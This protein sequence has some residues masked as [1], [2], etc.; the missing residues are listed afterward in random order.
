MTLSDAG[1]VVVPIDDRLIAHVE[2]VCDAVVIKLLNASPEMLRAA[3]LSRV[4]TLVIGPS[5]PMLGGASSAYSWAWDFMTDARSKA[6]LLLR[7]F[8]LLQVA[9]GSHSADGPSARKEPLVLLADDDPDLTIL[10]EATLRNDGIASRIANNGLDT[11]RL[12]RELLP[13]LVV[14]DVRMPGM[15]GFAVL[16]TIRIDPSLQTMPVILLTGCDDP[17]D[18]ALGAKLKASDYLRKPVSPGGLLVRVRRSLTA[19]AT[20]STRWVRVSPGNQHAL[21]G[22]SQ[23]RWIQEAVSPEM[24]GTTL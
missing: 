7:I 13:D 21:A 1:M 16:R 6:E 19:N 8:R 20:R 22:G 12:V 9:R 15:D 24:A 4:P 17:D 5:E 3:V 18:V 23:R 11:L 2:L 10:V 14:L